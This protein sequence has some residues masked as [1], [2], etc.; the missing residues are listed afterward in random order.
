[1]V[2]VHGAGGSRLHWPGE[3]RRLEGCRVF[4]VDLPGHGRSD[5]P[6]YSRIIDYSNAL[7]HWKEELS[8]PPVVIVGHS[9]GGAIALWTAVRRQEHVRGLVI[10]G[11]GGHLPVNTR[12]M[13]EL[14]QQELRA[15]G[16]EK[17]I[18]WSF[19]P[20]TDSTLIEAARE[21]LGGVPSSLLLGDY[22]ACSRYD[23][24]GR[25]PEIKIPVLILVGEADRMTPVDLSHELAELIPAARLSVVPDAGHMLMLEKPQKVEALIQSFLEEI[26]GR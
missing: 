13:A 23:I 25:L 26:E 8:I 21:Q 10:I 9:M 6:G 12:L 19:G 2:L 11:S 4:T 20:E 7:I 15:I 14:A 1:M 3:L 18:R 22:L 17:I 16:L 5:G 24:R